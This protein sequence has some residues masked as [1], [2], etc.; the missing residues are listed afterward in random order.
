MKLKGLI[1]TCDA[2]PS[3]WDARTTGDDRPV[4]IRYRH[5]RL[6][7]RVG[8]PGGDTDSALSWIEIYHEYIGGELDGSIEWKEVKKRTDRIDIEGTLDKWAQNMGF[9]TAR[10]T[11]AGR[12]LEWIEFD[13]KLAL[14][15][16]KT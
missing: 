1:Q 12:V 6:S 13:L 16:P 2:C 3:Q 11:D 8:P 9:Y 15:F 10:L 14:E 4:Y 7:V 5:G